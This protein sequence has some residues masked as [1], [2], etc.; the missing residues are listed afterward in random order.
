MLTYIL[1]ALGAIS[2]T[3]FLLFRTK[4]GG[5]VPAM[6]KTLTS[7]LFVATALSAAVNNYIVTGTLGVERLT[8]MALVI[9]GLVTGLIGDLTLDLKI[10]YQVSN[11]HHSDIYTFIGMGAFGVGHILYVIAVALYFGFSAWTI[12]I[13]AAAT[14]LIFTV[15]I[16]L[17]KM[18]FGKFLIPAIAYSFLLI[19]FLA[20]TVAAGLITAFTVSTILLVTGAALFLASDLVLSMTYF[21][22]ND[23]RVMIVVNHVLYYGAQFAIALSLYYLGTSL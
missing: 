7:L 3:F 13:A 6:I 21:D 15:S 9:L 12:L 20:S 8:F 16:F 22:G 1:L 5:L 2:L 4:E 10:T 23:S 11:L 19:L 17:L 14:A 18:K